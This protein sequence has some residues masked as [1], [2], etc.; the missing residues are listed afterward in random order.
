M[1]VLNGIGASRT[2]AVAAPSVPQTL[3]VFFW[4]DPS[5]EATIVQT[6]GSVSQWGD[7][8]PNGYHL[9]QATGANQPSYGARYINGLKAVDFDG[10][11]DTMLF[12]SGAYSI[13]T[14]SNT[15]LMVLSPDTL[16]KATQ[17]LIGNVGGADNGYT[18]G[19]DEYSGTVI[20]FKQGGS[21]NPAQSTPS[22]S[23]FILG[24]RRTAT[25]LEGLYNGVVVGTTSSASNQTLTA[26]ALSRNGA[27]R[28]ID[29]LVGEV[30]ACNQSLSNGDLNLLGNYLAAKWGATWTG[31]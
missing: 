29:G 1:L 25:L 30:V 5:D 24:F 16:A 6:A 18:I 9:T 7:K 27:G 21:V 28:Q 14:G 4:F 11:N 17:P 20:D 13:A 26:L 8:S 2:A 15:F 3:P 19:I 31:I 23:A 22:G 12:P 10:T